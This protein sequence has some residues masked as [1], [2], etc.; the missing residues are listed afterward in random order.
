MY[1]ERSSFPRL[2]ASALEDQRTHPRPLRR[3]S[4]VIPHTSRDYA[5]HTSR[6]LDRWR[7]DGA[8]FSSTPVPKEPLSW[9]AESMRSP[10]GSLPT[11]SQTLMESIRS[12]CRHDERCSYEN[13]LDCLGKLETEGSETE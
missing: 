4:I 1:Y 5:P 3:H 9:H 2:E 12:V 8:L 11:Q 7:L 13:V 6:Q 10:L